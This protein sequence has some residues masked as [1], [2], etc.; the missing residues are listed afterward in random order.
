MSLRVRLGQVSETIKTCKIL[1]ILNGEKCH[2]GRNVVWGEMSWGE[3][4]QGEMLRGE[5]SL[6]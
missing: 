6:G 2:M 3:M 1:N 4:S 5:L